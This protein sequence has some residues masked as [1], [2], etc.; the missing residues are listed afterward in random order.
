MCSSAMPRLLWNAGTFGLTSTAFARYGTASS[1][2]PCSRNSRPRLFSDHASLS[3]STI[4]RRYASTASSILFWRRIGTGHQ[5]RH[6][7][8]LGIDLARARQLRD[9]IVEAL[10]L[11]EHAT[12]VHVALDVLR[13]DAQ[14]DLEGALALR[15]VAALPRREPEHVVAPRVLGSPGRVLL[16]DRR[17][18]AVVLGLV[19]R[20]A[21]GERRR[22]GDLRRGGLVESFAVDVLERHRFARRRGRLRGIGLRLRR[23]TALGTSD[24]G[25]C[26]QEQHR[27]LSVGFHMPSPLCGRPDAADRWRTY[28][29]ARQPARSGGTEF[30]QLVWKA[31][32]MSDRARADRCSVSAASTCSA[33]HG[34]VW[35]AEHGAGLETG[36]W[37]AATTGESATDS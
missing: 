23:L 36:L 4:A 14:R 6:L 15:E 1:V 3:L 10:L 2:N 31:S 29:Q 8:R 17:R 5:P 27:D 33:G 20:L 35:L 21:V 26:Q 24:D 34:R 30:R 19:R 28:G 11:D 12:Q 37:R 32:G 18:I 7:D 25:A 9:R 16:E 13:I 22:R